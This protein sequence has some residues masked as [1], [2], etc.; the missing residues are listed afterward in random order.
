MLLMLMLF[1]MCFLLSHDASPPVVSMDILNS[2][3]SKL[4]TSVNFS[5]AS[6]PSTLTSLHGCYELFN[7]V[8]MKR[9]MRTGY[10]LDEV[11]NTYRIL[12]FSQ[13]KVRMEMNTCMEVTLYNSNSM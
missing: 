4:V 8:R 13:T 10:C 9:M 11:G 5:K 3:T 2:S 1:I 12:V 6:S 7:C